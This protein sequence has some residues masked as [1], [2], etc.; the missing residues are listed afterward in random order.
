M[1]RN[2]KLK[3]PATASSISASR[4]LA[5]AVAGTASALG[6]T[7]S[8]EAAIDVFDVAETINATPGHRVTANFALPA[9]H[10]IELIHA[11]TTLQSQGFRG[12]A[13]LIGVGNGL[14]IRGFRVS[15]GSKYASKLSFGA[16]VAIGPFLSNTRATLAYNNGFPNSQWKTAGQGYLGFKFNDANGVTEYGWMSLTLSG[17]PNNVV[18]INSYAYGTAGEVLTAGQVPEPGSLSLL[19]LGGAGLFAWRRRRA[20]LAAAATLPS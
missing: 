16:N 7:T 1:N 20:Q 3:S 13:Y 15:G 17:T 6:A 8:A 12:A 4:W 18:T 5:Y 2:R 10:S 11:R 14:S 9:Y 19:A